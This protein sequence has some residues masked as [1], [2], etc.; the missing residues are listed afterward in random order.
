MQMPYSQWL[1][2]DFVSSLAGENPNYTRE[3]RFVSA[4]QI[5]DGDQQL[6]QSCHR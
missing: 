3:K 6:G 4:W 5:L 2:H 1:C